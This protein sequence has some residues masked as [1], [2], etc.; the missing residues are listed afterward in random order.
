MSIVWVVI[1]IAVCWRLVHHSRLGLHLFAVGG[2]SSVARSYGVSVERTTVA[3]Y[4]LSSTF[5]AAAGVF[6]A[7][8]IASGDPKI[9]ELFAIESITAV[10]LGG[11]QLAG[12]VGS[13]PGALTGV[14]LLALLANGMNLENMSAFVQT[15][16]KG[17]I[18]LAV[19]AMQPRKTIGL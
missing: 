17:L 15:A 19:I 12:G 16:V 18:L 1:A 6:L 10:A 8:R 3:A 4:V 2:G 11:V 14:A 9:G 7:G 13:V 5:A